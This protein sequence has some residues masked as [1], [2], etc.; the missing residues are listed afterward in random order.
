M[1]SLTRFFK[2][3]LINIQVLIINVRKRTR[4]EM[5]AAEL[6]EEGD[7]TLVGNEYVRWF[8]IRCWFY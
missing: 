5:E 3:M 4:D 1:V 8:Q 6:E 2:D 7:I